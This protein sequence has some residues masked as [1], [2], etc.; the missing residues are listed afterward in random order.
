MFLSSS[1]KF[2]FHD[3][4]LIYLLYIRLDKNLLGS[5][6]NILLPKQNLIITLFIYVNSKYLW[7]RNLVTDLNSLI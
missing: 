7:D 1:H 2:N 4:F 3:L 6:T 5:D